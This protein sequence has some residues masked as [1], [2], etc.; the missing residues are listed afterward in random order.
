M[1]IPIIQTMT[2]KLMTVNTRLTVDDIYTDNTIAACKNPHHN[3]E[4][5]NSCATVVQVLKDLFYVLLH[6]LF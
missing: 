2:A 5:C 1:P 4:G 6:I 3:Y